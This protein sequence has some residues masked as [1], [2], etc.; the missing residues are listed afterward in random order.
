MREAL[1]AQAG[2]DGGVRGGSP[3]SV[4][5]DH[6]GDPADGLRGQG[7]APAN[8]AA[9][10]EDASRG[11]APGQ[12][13]VQAVLV[14][15]SVRVPDGSIQI[16]IND[17]KDQRRLGPPEKMALLAGALEIARAEAIA[18]LTTGSVAREIRAPRIAIAQPGA[19]ELLAGHARRPR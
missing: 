13:T 15:M 19:A 17:A 10:V 11:G 5:Q 12:V 3:L 9:P 4:V 2:E 6:A 18:G 7:S 16:V 14:V 8:D 1:G